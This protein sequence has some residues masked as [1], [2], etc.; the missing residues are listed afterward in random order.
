MDYCSMVFGRPWMSPSGVQ[1]LVSMIRGE[2]RGFTFLNIASF[3]KE[4]VSTLLE[5]MGD[6]NV[7]EEIGL[8]V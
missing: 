7:V 3:G 4:S 6:N 1:V 2:A 8:S 5:A